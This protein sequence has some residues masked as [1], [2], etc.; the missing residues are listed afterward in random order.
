[1]S[2]R[3]FLNHHPQIDE[4][5]YIDPMA[6]VLG[7]VRLG[8]DASVWPMSTLRGD[9]H[10]IE[11]GERSNI[12][13][14]SVLHCTSPHTGAPDGY[15]LVIGNDVTIGHNVILHGCTIGNECLIGMGAIILDGAVIQDRVM[16]AAGSL[17]SPGKV[18]ESG[19]LYLGNPAR[20]ARDLSE[21]ELA[22]FKV[23]AEHYVRLKN[24][25]EED[26]E[27]LE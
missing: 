6:L 24:Q 8:K 12:Q 22:F 14:G 19:G 21:E 18:L 7:R 15:P 9:V 1:M 11:V 4:G 16:L 26:S 2:I 17:V 3:R 10:D 13:D 20:R 5:A 27:V 23:S 25:H